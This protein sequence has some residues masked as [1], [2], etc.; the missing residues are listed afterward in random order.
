[1]RAPLTLET[2]PQRG[3]EARMGLRIYEVVLRP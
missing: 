3:E 1:M 2:L